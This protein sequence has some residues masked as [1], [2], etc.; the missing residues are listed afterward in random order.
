MKPIAITS[1]VGNYL[2]L[3]SSLLSTLNGESPLQTN[4]TEPNVAYA[5]LTNYILSLTAHF[6]LSKDEQ[7]TYFAGMA[8]QLI[9]QH[10]DTVYTLLIERKKDAFNLSFILDS[11]FSEALDKSVK[12]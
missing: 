4:D 12:H 6:E 2:T 11:Q 5:L 7:V 8:D 1:T 9:S 3:L 10:P